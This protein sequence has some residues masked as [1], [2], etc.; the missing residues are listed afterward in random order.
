MI[1]IGGGGAKLQAN[2]Y[3]DEIPIEVL[4]YPPKDSYLVNQVL[5]S[6]A[7]N[8]LICRCRRPDVSLLSF[9]QN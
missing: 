3:T 4:V 2:K 6:A 9:K 1:F 7:Q 5:G 8:S